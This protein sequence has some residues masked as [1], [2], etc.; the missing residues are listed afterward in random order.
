M[1]SAAQRLLR[2]R[3][4]LRAAERGSGLIRT[5]PFGEREEGGGRILHV[6]GGYAEL[7][8]ALVRLLPVGG[9]AGLLN[10]GDFG[11][12]AAARAG[13][14]LG[15]VLAVPDPKGQE[16][17]VAALLVEA[18]DIVCIGGGLLNTRQRRALAAK[19][20]SRRCTL[21]LDAPWPGISRPCGAARPEEAA[22]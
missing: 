16:A 20:R 4:A 22:S 19:A 10:L 17:G 3:E 2:A 11:W 8:D 7:I 15:R 12:E 18:F 6:E 5:P 14:E 21:L 9:W 13:L 1:E